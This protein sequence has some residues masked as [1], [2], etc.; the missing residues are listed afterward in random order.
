MA[1]EVLRCECYGLNVCIT[2]PIDSDVEAAVL[3]VVLLALG[4]CGNYRLDS[5]RQLDLEI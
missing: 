5:F 2:P 3:R 1:G 4:P